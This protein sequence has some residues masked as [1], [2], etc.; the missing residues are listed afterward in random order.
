MTGSM[1]GEDAK[2]GM[3]PLRNEL[4]KGRLKSKLSGSGRD[5]LLQRLREEH[6]C[7][8]YKESH[9]DSSFGAVFVQYGRR[10]TF[11]SSLKIAK[12]WRKKKQND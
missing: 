6:F 8:A 9:Y 7:S 11:G 5:N 12:I 1:E 3:P 10:S 4:V 2:G